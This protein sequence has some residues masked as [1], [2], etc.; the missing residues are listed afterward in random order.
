MEQMSG[1]PGEIVTRLRDRQ[2]KHAY[3]DGGATIQRFLAAGLIDP[4]SHHSGAGPDRRRYSVVWSFAPR[5][6]SGTHC[7]ALL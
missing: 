7:D 4:L 6:H 3:I 1:E 2:Y 5:H